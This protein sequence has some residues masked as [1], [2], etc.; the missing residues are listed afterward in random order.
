MFFG[1]YPYFAG[2]ERALLELIKQEQLD[3]NKNDVKISS[4]VIVF[5]FIQKKKD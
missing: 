5:F 1:S 4:D 2:N 3:W